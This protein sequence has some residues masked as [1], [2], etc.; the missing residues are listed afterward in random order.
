MTETALGTIAVMANAGGVS[1][2]FAVNDDIA[3]I[4]LSALNAMNLAMQISAA[5][6]HCAFAS[7]QDIGEIIRQALGEWESS[8][9]VG[10]IN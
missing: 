7:G 9:S 6:H 1:I 3:T 8:S 10:S 2:S 4:P 5:A